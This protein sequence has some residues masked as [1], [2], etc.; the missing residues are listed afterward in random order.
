[1]LPLL[2]VVAVFCATLKLTWQLP[3]QDE[4]AVTVIQEALLVAVHGAPAVAVTFT[5]PEP[6]AAVND[7]LVG[8][9]E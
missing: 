6:P 3:L 9:R 5:V 8:E 4:P 1:M 7:W 2:L